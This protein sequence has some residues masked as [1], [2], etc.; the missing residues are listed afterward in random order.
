MWLNQWG[1]GVN[2][3]QNFKV[4]DGYKVIEIL[5][6]PKSCHTK[7]GGWRVIIGCS[8]ET[9]VEPV[10]CK[11]PN[12]CMT[13]DVGQWEIGQANQ[14]HMFSV[15]FWNPKD[16]IFQISGKI[17]YNN[18]WAFQMQE[19]MHESTHVWECQKLILS[20]SIRSIIWPKSREHFKLERLSASN[21]GFRRPNSYPYSCLFGTLRMIKLCQPSSNVTSTLGS[22]SQE[23]NSSPLSSGHLFVTRA[24]M[25]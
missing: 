23:S 21:T 16:H 24:I 12:N 1:I 15:V 9:G 14:N 8:L 2:D 25:E 22:I 4:C 11:E 5:T 20:V 3:I 18:I 13:I 19:D 7:L 10:G 17:F 6:W